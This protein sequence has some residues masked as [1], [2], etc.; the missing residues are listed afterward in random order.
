MNAKRIGSRFILDHSLAAAKMWRAKKGYL[1][2]KG[3]LAATS[4]M[5]PHLLMLKLCRERETEREWK[6]IIF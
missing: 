4:K 2:N 5:A 3:S 1:I 6:S